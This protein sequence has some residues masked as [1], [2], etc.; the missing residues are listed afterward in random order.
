MKKP[1]LL[2]FPPPPAT[3][4]FPILLGVKA[5]SLNPSHVTVTILKKEEKED[6]GNN[7]LI[8]LTSIHG[9]IT[10]Q[11]I[12]DFISKHLEERKMIRKVTMDSLRASHSLTT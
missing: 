4:A 6:L 2:F 8:N 5:L 7:R 9:K 10:E 1:A 12:K 3:V 11:V